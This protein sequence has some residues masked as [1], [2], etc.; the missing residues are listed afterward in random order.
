MRGKI[1]MIFEITG[2]RR[3]SP[4]KQYLV[5]DTDYSQ[6]STPTSNFYSLPFTLYSLFFIFYFLTS[7]FYPHALQY[8][9][10]IIA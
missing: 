6:I 3:L 7:N 5:R 9:H 4:D 1:L 10:Q 2:I 8:K